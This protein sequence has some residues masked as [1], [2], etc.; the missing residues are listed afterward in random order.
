VTKKQ[1]K[2]ITGIILANM[3]WPVI[4]GGLL[5]VGFYTLLRSGVIDSPLMARYFSTHPVQYFEAT[6][7]AVGVAA[8][9]IKAMNV[10]GQFGTL[11]EIDVAPKPPG[12]QE[13]AE[14]EGMLESLAKLPKCA[15]RSYLG[16]RLQ[17]AL[18][19][20]S[21]KGT[22]SG[23]EHELKHL[24]DMDAARQ[25]DGF[26]LVRIIIWATPMLGFLGTVIGITLA[27]SDLSPQALV[28]TPETAM[29][30][31]LAGLAVA[32]DTTALA[33]VLSIVLMFA[34]YLTVSLETELL[35]AVDRRVE[36]ELM[37]RFKQLGTD[38]DPHLESIELMSQRVVESVGGTSTQMLQNVEQL[39]QRQADLWNSTISEAQNSWNGATQ[40]AGTAL[41]SAMGTALHDAMQQH[42]MEL[43]HHER[44]A[45]DRAE[46][47][48]RALQ[49]ALSQNAHVIQGQQAELVRQ[50]DILLKTMEGIGE[51]SRRQDA[52]RTDPSV[53]EKMDN[54]IMKLSAAID[55]LN[56]R[57]APVKDDR[58]A[59]LYP[60]QRGKA[61]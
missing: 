54:T 27:L 39:V 34:Q 51:M 7:F 14:A 9:F 30:G 40:A 31:L 43:A 33:L 13:V 21:R 41:E 3:G 26:A 1:S 15:C 17:Q 28:S 38:S 20:V 47:H 37:G 19:Y 25:H 2:S 45:N 29:D 58:P 18:Q 59:R 11:R 53:A 35:D 32:F 46:R 4:W 52:M 48:W 6:L 8:I 61:A 22:A 10:V 49:E 36:A 57:L 12:G 42:S 23:L 50:G 60:R 24:S 16:R 55:A 44:A 5:T 56:T